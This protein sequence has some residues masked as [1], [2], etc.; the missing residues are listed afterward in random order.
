MQL[1]AYFWR[2]REKVKARL[3]GDKYLPAVFSAIYRSNAW[4]DQESR[5]G[6]GSNRNATR[7]IRQ[8]LPDLFRRRQ[9]STLLDA[10]CGDFNWMAEVVPHLENYYG[11]D[12]V[13]ELIRENQTQHQ[14]KQ[15]HFQCANLA[16]D[17]L[18]RAD[19]VLCR[20]CFIHLSTN[21]I[22]SSLNNFKKTGA[23]YLLLSHQN[24]DITYL[25][26]V[27]GSCRPIN[28]HKPPFNFPKPLEVIPED[29]QGTRQLCLWELDKLQVKS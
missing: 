14:R 28:F 6:T 13:P 10:P 27:P 15:I 19:L 5:S 18:P 21:L 24:E 26:I 2:L 25:D 4:A 29:A 12:I 3:M 17:P 7:Q 22:W 23:R 9:I 1:R 20:D 16:T 11:V 8:S